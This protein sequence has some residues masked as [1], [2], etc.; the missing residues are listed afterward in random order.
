MK[1]KILSLLTLRVKVRY[2]TFSLTVLHWVGDNSDLPLNSNIS[3]TVSV[4]IAFTGTFFKEYL[5][6]FLMVSRLIDFA[7]SVLNKLMYQ[8]CRIIGISKIKFF[9]LNKIKKIKNHSKPPKLVCQPLFKKFQENLN[10]FL[11]FQ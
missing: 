1:T 5:I 11:V 4:N 9:N 8:V 6:S 2:L 3:K 7:L 10:I